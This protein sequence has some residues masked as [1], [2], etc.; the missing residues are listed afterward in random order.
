MMMVITQNS[1]YPFFSVGQFR[2]T[3]VPA[4]C[5]TTT[6]YAPSFFNATLLYCSVYTMMHHEFRVLFVSSL[7]IPV[8]PFMRV[9]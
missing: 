4:R 9:R 2:R 1:C 8:A 6:F 3:V 5:I 7:A